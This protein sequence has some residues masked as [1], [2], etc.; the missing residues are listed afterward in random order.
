MKF[1]ILS[2]ARSLL[3]LFVVVLTSCHVSRSL[4]IGISQTAFDDGKS[5][6]HTV[7]HCTDGVPVTWVIKIP[8]VLLS[9]RGLMHLSQE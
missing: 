1:Q 8:P 9:Q 7:L 5:E 4:L 6:L 3:V 2:L